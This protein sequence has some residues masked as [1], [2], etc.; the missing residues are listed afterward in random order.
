M[1]P[2][3]DSNLRTQIAQRPN[4]GVSKTEYLGAEVEAELTRL[5][6]K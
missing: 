4:Y 1:M 5:F 3:D 2:C 6:E